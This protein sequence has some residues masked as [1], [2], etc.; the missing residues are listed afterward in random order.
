[1]SL[2]AK[3]TK[4][5]T[6]SG[7]ASS[8]SSVSS[9][10]QGKVKDDVRGLP[11]SANVA[12][13]DDLWLKMQGMFEKT[14]EKIESSKTELVERIAEV[15]SQ[16]SSVREECSI[17]INKLEEAV[18]SVRHDLERTVETVDRSEKRD[19]LIIS[20]VPFQ[21]N[22]NLSNIFHNISLCLDY[23]ETNL[24]LVELKRLARQPI[25]RGAI[26]PILCEFT[27][28]L[29]RNEFYR[30]YLNRRSLCLRNV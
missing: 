2:N 19:E 1:M 3:V 17:S 11:E 22:E 21:S 25:A 14:N 5:L 9:E 6:R 24:P 10:L 29:A 26:V 30:R 15:E 7:S 27:H 13:L 28:R 20:G 12:N 16:L 18:G 4:P 8:A 23:S